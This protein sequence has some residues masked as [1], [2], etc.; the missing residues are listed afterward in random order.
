[1]KIKIAVLAFAMVAIL[2]AYAGNQ[3]IR[4]LAAYTGMSER[5]VKMILG[6]RTAYAEYPYT[7]ERYKARFVRTLGKDKYERLISGEPVRL[8]NGVVV[9]IQG[10]D[11]VAAAE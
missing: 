7:Y 11:Q 5:K 2:P 1:M 9:R 4:D 6:T 8:D 3:D 10:V